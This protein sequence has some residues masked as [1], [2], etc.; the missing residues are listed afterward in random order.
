[1]FRNGVMCSGAVEHNCAGQQMR[2]CYVLGRDH[3]L[4]DSEIEPCL[5][6]LNKYDNMPGVK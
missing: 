5:V 1:M 6:S 3:V 2:A 4:G